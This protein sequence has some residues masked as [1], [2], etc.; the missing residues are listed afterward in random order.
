MPTRRQELHM[1]RD[2]VGRASTLAVVITALGKPDRDV[3]EAELARMSAALDDAEQRILTRYPNADF[4]RPRRQIKY[5]TR[6]ATIDVTVSELVD[7]RITLAF[8]PR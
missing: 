4:R 5:Q 1:V 6:F 7:G 2:I 3:T 8:A